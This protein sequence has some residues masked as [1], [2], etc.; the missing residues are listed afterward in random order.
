MG[1]GNYHTT[2]SLSFDRPTE[3]ILLTAPLSTCTPLVAEAPAIATTTR[4]QGVSCLA[5]RIF[6]Y[7]I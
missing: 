2:P 7:G 5:Y 4:R 6:K 3:T 1:D